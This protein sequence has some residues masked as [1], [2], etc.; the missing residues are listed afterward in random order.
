[1]SKQTCTVCG[2][3]KALSLFAKLGSG[4]RR[5]QCKACINARARERYAHSSSAR[6]SAKDNARR[7]KLNNRFV[8]NARARNRIARRM[9]LV[10][11]HGP[12]DILAAVYH[13]SGRCAYCSE[14]LGRDYT[15]DHVI[16]STAGGDTVP[17]N[18]VPACRQCNSSKGALPLSEWWRPTRA[19]LDTLTNYVADA[20]G[21]SAE[22]LHEIAK[23]RPTQEK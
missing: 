21:A 15:V 4:R 6:E 19:Q 9:G 11:D 23:C 14:L 22:L 12:R 18:L 16:P 3:S 8:C 7:W 17:A 20:R 5:R 13:W 1:M 10:A 2:A